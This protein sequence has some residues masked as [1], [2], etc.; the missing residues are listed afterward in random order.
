MNKFK[1][2]KVFDCQDMPNDIM[3]KFLNIDRG[4]QNNCC[5][6]YTAEGGRDEDYDIVTDWLTQNGAEFGEEVIIKRWW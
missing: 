3:E 1:L 4:L 6:E 5:V 2:Y